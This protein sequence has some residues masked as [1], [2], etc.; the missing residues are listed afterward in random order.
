MRPAGRLI[1][2]ALDG[3]LCL[4]SAHQIRPPKIPKTGWLQQLLDLLNIDITR[5]RRTSKRR[6]HLFEREHSVVGV[7][8]RLADWIV[9]EPVHA[10]P[11]MTFRGA[12]E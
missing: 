10:D 7:R 3:W 6:A 5:P 12:G 9:G 1:L 4:I 8:C 11:E 2:E